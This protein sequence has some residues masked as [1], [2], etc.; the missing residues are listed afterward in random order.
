MGWPFLLALLAM[1]RAMAESSMY[2]ASVPLG[3]QRAPSLYAPRASED[4]AAADSNLQRYGPRS[5]S[6]YSSGYGTRSGD[7]YSRSSDYYSRG[8]LPR[9]SDYYSRSYSSRSSDYSQGYAP[10]SSSYYSQ[11]Y[12]SRSSDYYS[13]GYGSRSGDYYSQ[14]YG[15]RRCSSV[16]RISAYEKVKV[17]YLCQPQTGQSLP[18]PKNVDEATAFVISSMLSEGWLMCNHAVVVPVYRYQSV[19]SCCPG[20]TPTSNGDCVK[21]ILEAPSAG[22]SPCANGGRLLLKNGVATCEC[23]SGYWGNTCQQTI[24]DGDSSTGG[25]SS[26]GQLL[27]AS[28][29]GGLRQNNRDYSSSSAASTQLPPVMVQTPRPLRGLISRL[30]SSNFQPG[31]LI[32]QVVGGQGRPA[33]FGRK[34]VSQGQ[35]WTSSTSRRQFPYLRPRGPSY[36]TAQ[37]SPPGQPQTHNDMSSYMAAMMAQ[38][39]LANQQ[40]WERQMMMRH[41]MEQTMRRRTLQQQQAQQQQPQQQQQQQPQPPQ[42]QEQQQ[43]QQQQQPLQQE[44][45]E[46]DVS[47]Q[48]HTDTSQEVNSDPNPIPAPLLTSILTTPPPNQQ[49]NVE[50][51]DEG[52]VM[53]NEQTTQ[54]SFRPGAIL[55]QLPQLA[56]E[57]RVQNEMKPQ[58]FANSQSSPTQGTASQELTII[59]RIAECKTKTEALL[60]G[61]LAQAG[62]TTS[63]FD[64][65]NSQN[66]EQLSQVCRNSQV[67]GPCIM[68]QAQDLCGTDQ[69]GA[70]GK[71]MLQSTLAFLGQ[72]CLRLRIQEEATGKVATG[73][74]SP[75]IFP[76]PAPSFPD[77]VSS[78]GTTAATASP[79]AVDAKV[80]GGDSSVP[81]ARDSAARKASLKS[82]PEH[83]HKAASAHMQEPVI[84]VSKAGMFPMWVILAMAGGCGALLL[85][86][87]LVV[88]LCVRCRRKKKSI[89]LERHP[90][91]LPPAAE[92]NF[93]MISP[94]T[95][96]PEYQTTAV[97]QE[98]EGEFEQKGVK[99]G[100]DHAANED[101][102][103]AEG[104][105]YA[106]CKTVDKQKAAND[107]N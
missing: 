97:K 44:S 92:N 42:Q 81:S 21:N 33:S 52:P 64:I 6:Y 41:V 53:V 36:S 91:K 86:T 59:Q 83:E 34:G 99:E 72:F 55:E 106:T 3:Y 107:D 11:V 12:G 7:Y 70:V 98:V 102:L 48:E 25:V 35:S 94:F 2:P 58:M 96:P 19:S 14:G 49:P 38:Q 104:N 85:L 4:S 78:A 101:R 46:S 13:R 75:P 26:P 68:Q 51:E 105:E 90:E 17:P 63:L 73:M 67:I 32:R 18:V 77:R 9:S 50:Y 87:C 89:D 71:R 95:P 56:P 27:M 37:Q 54:S 76:N 79:P 43:Q 10:R 65:I 69:V 62:I 22:Q 28:V 82:I 20:S 45:S 84:E 16:R 57:E 29:Y 103:R 61:C 80:S 47:Q 1:L 24:R 40:Q 66:Q 15:S 23:R 100:K 8:Y 74:T 30:P 60:N 39:A 93:Y 31:S 5:G 88:C